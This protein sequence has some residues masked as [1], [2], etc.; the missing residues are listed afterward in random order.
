M[1]SEAKRRRMM[2]GSVSRTRGS[3][4]LCRRCP[5]RRELK[6]RNIL[7]LN[8]AFHASVSQQW[9]SHHER[10]C[11]QAAVLG[12]TALKTHPFERETA[13]T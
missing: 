10:D 7:R 9:S 11:T 6:R 5:V 4:E 2:T 13:G 3:G 1:R 12:K 8:T